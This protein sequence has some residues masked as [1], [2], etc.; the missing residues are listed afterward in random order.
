MGE[1]DVKNTLE[2]GEEDVKI[3]SKWVKK[4]SKYTRNG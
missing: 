2:M 4:M 1:E 3:H